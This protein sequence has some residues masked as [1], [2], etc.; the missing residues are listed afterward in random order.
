[1]KIRW[2]MVVAPIIDWAWLLLALTAAIA[3]A[4]Q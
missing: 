3:E 2:W 1:M 4:N